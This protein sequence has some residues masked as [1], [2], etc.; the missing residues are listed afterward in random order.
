MS[1]LRG[2][3][4]PYYLYDVI[5]S[6]AY[7][8]HEED[9]LVDR[10]IKLLQWCREHDINVYG[11]PNAGRH[12]DHNMNRYRTGDAYGNECHMS[13]T[14]VRKLA[15]TLYEYAEDKRQLRRE[16]L[17][18]VRAADAKRCEERDKRLAAEHRKW[19]ERNASRD[20]HVGQGSLEHVCLS[21]NE[22]RQ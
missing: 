10:V 1:S 14:A 9:I 5:I 20:E 12:N 15:K 18:R 7:A 17:E 4:K 16:F 8:W 2:N 6:M 3:V 13:W 11:N 21:G 22:V 19:R